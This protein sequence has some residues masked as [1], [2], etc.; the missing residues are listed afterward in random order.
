MG[1]DKVSPK[2]VLKSGLWY[3]ISNF[4]FRA[5]AFITTPIFARILTKAEYGEFNNISSWI[6]ILLILA[7]CDLYTSIIRAKLDYED[8]L[9]R[10]AFSMQT[11]ESIITVGMFIVF[12]IFRT[13]ISNL[14]GIEEKYFYIIFIYILFVQ[15]Y[16]VFITNERAHYKYKAFS[17]ITGIGIIASSALSVILVLTLHNKLDARVYGQYIPYVFIGAVLYVLIAR[18]GKKIC[19]EYYKYGLLLSLPLVPHLLSM[20]L[21]GSSDRIMITKLLGA[22]YTALYSIAHIVASIVAILIDSMNK[23]WAPWFLDSMKGNEQKSIAKVSTIYF[24]VFLAL[25]LG[26]ILLAPEVVLT[27]GGKRY[28]EGVS[29]LPPLIIG[30]VFQFAYTMYVQVEF[31]EKKMRM[32]AIGTTIAAVLNIILNFIFIPIWGYC[33]AGYTTLAGY[34]VLFLLHY[35]VI[36]RLGYRHIFNRKVIF[37]GLGLSLASIPLALVLYQA[38]IV[39]YSVIVLYIAIMLFVIFRYRKLI[40]NFISSKKGDS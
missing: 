19:F 35:I 11:L 31:Y 23:A 18:K 24:G 14:M 27:L 40:H 9:N 4:A 17:I 13:S 21:L 12:M 36:S 15:G 5:V 29:V 2:I 20:T 28:I 6:T 1:K 25:I 26:I 33:A 3:T 34:A 7:S 16:Y 37:G 32:V 8:D 22:E 38:S 10:Y 30:C 39:R